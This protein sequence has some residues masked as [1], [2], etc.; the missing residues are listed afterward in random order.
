[1]FNKPTRDL[2]AEWIAEELHSD[3]VNGAYWLN[4]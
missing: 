4:V 1:L 3:F 2:A